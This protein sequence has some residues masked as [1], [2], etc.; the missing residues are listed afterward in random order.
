MREI[1]YDQ[2][3]DLIYKK[4]FP[5]LFIRKLPLILQ[6]ENTFAVSFCGE[7]VEVLQLYIIWEKSAKGQHSSSGKQANPINVISTPIPT[8]SNIM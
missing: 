3:N 6:W 4:G 8:V 1:F 5:W 2:W 7:P